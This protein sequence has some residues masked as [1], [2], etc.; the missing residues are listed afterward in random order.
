MLLGGHAQIDYIS[1][2]GTEI[3]SNG[4]ETFLGVFLDKDLKFD[5]HINFLCRKTAEKLGA[6]AGTNKYLSYDQKLLHVNSVVK[7]LFTF[8]PTDPE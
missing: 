5:A 2:N 3:E 1:V 6:I 4:S 8:F 7:S